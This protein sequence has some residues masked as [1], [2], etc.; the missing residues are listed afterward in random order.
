MGIGTK[1]MKTILEN[2]DLKDCSFILAASSQAMSF[3]EHLGFE[4]KNDKYM[5]F[6][7]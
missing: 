1:L 3:Y 7:K 6:R 5:L 2:D 4:I